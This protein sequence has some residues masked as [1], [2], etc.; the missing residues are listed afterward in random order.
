MVLLF[1]NKI[2]QFLFYSF[3]FFYKFNLQ[4]FY[5]ILHR[6]STTIQK[7]YKKIFFLF[8]VHSPLLTK[9]LLI[10]FI[11]ATKMFQFTKFLIYYFFIVK[12]VSFKKIISY[13]LYIF[14]LIFKNNISFFYVFF[15]FPRYP[16]NTFYIL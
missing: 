8:H 3:Y 10:F 14:Y 2:S 6:N 12:I 4:D 15:L 7:I 13:I 16:L 1:S 5:L 9:S 11:L